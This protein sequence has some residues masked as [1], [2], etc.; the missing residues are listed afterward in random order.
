MIPYCL[1]CKLALIK[2]LFSY[3]YKTG[4]TDTKLGLVNKHYQ[5]NICENTWTP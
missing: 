2:Y 4:S 1:V 3:F 5:G